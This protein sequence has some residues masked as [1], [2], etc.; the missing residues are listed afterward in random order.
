M[1]VVESVDS[2]RSPESRAKVITRL[3]PRS[4]SSSQTSALGVVAGLRLPA[5]F[6]HL[7]LTL[8]DSQQLVR[9]SSVCVPS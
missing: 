4:W 5:T 2:L 7:S 6:I 9:V 8:H 1:W 3:I